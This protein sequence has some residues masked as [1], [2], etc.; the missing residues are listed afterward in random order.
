MLYPINVMLLATR[1][2]DRC[3][4]EARGGCRNGIYRRR[5]AGLALWIN[6]SGININVPG[7]NIREN[8][9]WNSI[10]RPVAV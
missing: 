1:I 7:D 4:Y 5:I 3:C 6:K 9:V 2:H 8:S 10:Y